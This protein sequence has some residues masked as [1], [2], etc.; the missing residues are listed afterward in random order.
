MSLIGLQKCL[1]LVAIAASCWI[2]WLS[3]NGIVFERLVTTID[4]LLFH[5]KM[6]VLMWARAIHNECIFSESDWWSSLVK[7]IVG[8]RSMRSRD[9]VWGP[10]PMGR[11]KFN[12]AGFVMNE[13]AAC[14]GVLRDDKGVVSALFSGSCAARALE[15]AVLMAIKEATK[16]VIELIRK[17][18][19]PLIIKCN[20]S[21][22]SDWL[23]YS[24]LLP[25]SFRNLFT[26][27]EGSLRRMAEVR[28]EVTNQ[29]KNGMAKALAKVVLLRNTLFRAYW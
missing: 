9:L 22:V 24:C 1:W 2:V 14:G 6:R 3:Q 26:N 18:Q 7:C 29:G 21:T 19:V 5:P 13:I 28:I 12:V 15:M 25:W 16:M 11:I 23:K 10:P 17:E 8:G 27:I 4:A 20:S